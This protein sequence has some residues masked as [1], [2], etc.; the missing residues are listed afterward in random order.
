MQNLR[1]VKKNIV[2]FMF[3]GNSTFTIVEGDHHYS[4]KIYRKKTTDD[5]KIYHLYL[6]KSNKGTYS[7][8]FK[9]VDNRLTFKHSSKYDI[10]VDNEQLK[11]LLDTIHSRNALPENIKVYHSGRCGCCGRTLTD[12]ESMERGFGRE[13]WAKIKDYMI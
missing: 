10:P 9:I 8:Y 11:I 5:V 2:K 12:P 4:Y 13:C 7:G 6:K 1:E 3:A